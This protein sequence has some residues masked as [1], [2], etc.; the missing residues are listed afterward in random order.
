MCIRCMTQLLKWVEINLPKS[1][2]KIDS[3]AHALLKNERTK[4]V[5]NHINLDEIFKEGI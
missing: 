2:N 3:K 1:R 4:I 5:Y